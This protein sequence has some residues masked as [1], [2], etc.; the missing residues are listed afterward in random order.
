MAS[1]NI[2]KGCFVPVAKPVI[3][4][5]CG[6]LSYPSCLPRTG[7]RY[8]GGQFIDCQMNT[9]SSPSPGHSKSTELDYD[10]L[11]SRLGEMIRSEFDKLRKEF[12]DMYRADLAKVTS[13]IQS[14]NERISRMEATVAS[15]QFSEDWSLVS[16]PEV[17]MEDVLEELADREARSK[18]LIFHNLEESVGD[19]RVSGDMKRVNDIIKSILPGDTVNIV[20]QRLGKKSDD[21]SRPLR[22]TLTSK[23]KVLSILRNRRLYLGPVKISSD[24]TPRQRDYMAKFRER[25]RVMKS[26]GDINKTI[27]FIN[28]VPK[29]VNARALDQKTE[30]FFFDILSKCAWFKD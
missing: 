6:I 21:R 24:Q 3:C 30:I 17:I 14:I 11:L 15:H 27:R 7:H 8:S 9:G 29:I 4:M 23:D 1:K 5:G 10:N 25:L 22:V 2:C 20:C 28:G 13:E 18:N 26:A 19:P 12:L 16:R